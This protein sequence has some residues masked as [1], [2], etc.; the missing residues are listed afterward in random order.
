L[1]KHHKTLTTELPPISEERAHLL[2]HLG[3]RLGRRV[4]RKVIANAINRPEHLS[5]TNRSSFLSGRADGGRSAVVQDAFAS[6]GNQLSKPGKCISIWGDP[7]IQQGNKPRWKDYCIHPLRENEESAELLEEF[8]GMG[9][10]TSIGGLNQNTGLQLLQCSYEQLLSRGILTPEG[11]IGELAYVRTSE[12]GEPGFKSRIYTISEWF[13]TIFLQPLGHILVTALETLPSAKHGL[14]AGNPAWEWVNDF[15]LKPFATNDL[16][17]KL[18]L[19][20]SD[21]ETATDY[22]DHKVG[23]SLLNGF[24]SGLGLLTHTYFRLAVKLLCSPRYLIT[25]PSN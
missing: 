11:E 10:Y 23:Q 15:R 22:A 1:I 9:G 2:F 7:I 6:W 3:Q 24:L 18:M 4:D 21:L 5:V 25:E 12:C 13:V 20:T 16:L 17:K 8:E 19:L 14:S